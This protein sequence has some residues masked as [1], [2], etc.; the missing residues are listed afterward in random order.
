M[1]H[2]K[3]I[4]FPFLSV[5]LYREFF[6][7]GYNIPIFYSKYLCKI[8]LYTRGIKSWELTN[9]VYSGLEL[10]ESDF[11]EKIPPEGKQIM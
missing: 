8:L 6:I 11:G 10:E 1:A 4:H 9:I 3:V 2:I 5:D 7:Q